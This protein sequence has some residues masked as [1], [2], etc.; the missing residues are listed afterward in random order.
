MGAGAAPTGEQSRWRPGACTTSEYFLPGCPDSCSGLPCHPSQRPGPSSGL[1]LLTRALRLGMEEA[2]HGPSPP[3]ALPPL[4]LAQSTALYLDSPSL[5]F[6][7]LGPVPTRCLRGAS[8]SSRIALDRSPCFPAL[9]FLS[10][11][12][13]K[14]P[15][16]KCSVNNL[17][18]KLGVPE[19]QRTYYV[20]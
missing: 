3:T 20:P 5:A 9:W 18:L 11:A 15:G 16:N 1:L 4:A 10:S 19:T 7:F 2:L 8:W 12:R 6:P 17:G 14:L 13:S